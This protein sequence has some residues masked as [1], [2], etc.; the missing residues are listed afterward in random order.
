[1]ASNQHV[2][3]LVNLS[4]DD[5]N[6]FFADVDR[7]AKA[8]H[9]AFSPDKINYLEEDTVVIRKEEKVLSP[10]YKALAEELLQDMR[11]SLGE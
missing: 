11:K 3:E 2:S 5:R 6:G 4:D 10:K 1:M 9:K 7:V 8:L